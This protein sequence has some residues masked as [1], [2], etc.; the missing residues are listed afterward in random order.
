MDPC[1]GSWAISAG[2]VTSFDVP[3]RAARDWFDLE[4]ARNAAMTLRFANSFLFPKSNME[5]LWQ[6][7]EQKDIGNNPLHSAC[8]Q[9]LVVQ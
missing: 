2:L 4:L 9:D 6:Q 8:M 7:H 5:K 3:V 1:K